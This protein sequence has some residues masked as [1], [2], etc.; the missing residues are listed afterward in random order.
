ME[1]PII[2][3]APMDG[4]TDA[5][6]RL[7]AARYAKPHFHITE[8]TSVE[9][10]CHGALKSLKAFLYDEIERPIVAQMFGSD[11]ESFYKSAFVVCELGFDGIDIN[12]GCPANNVAS[13]G[14]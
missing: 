4:V 11:P 6:F 12:M 13:K 14:A 5:P 10:I 2:G 3:L 7:I 1:K 8:F 9:G